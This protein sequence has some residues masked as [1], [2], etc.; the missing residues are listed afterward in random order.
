[1][2]KTLRSLKAEEIG[3]RL[4]LIPDLPTLKTGE[5]YL[6]IPKFS[7]LLAFHGLQYSRS[8][9]YTYQAMPKESLPESFKQVF[10]NQ[11]IPWFI[12][13]TNSKAQSVVPL[14]FLTQEMQKQAVRRG[15]TA[16][17]GVIAPELCTAIDD[18]LADAGRRIHQLLTEG[19]HHHGNHPITS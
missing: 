6:T 19:T 18:I 9:L 2:R 17:H 14:R 15:L 3:R 12:P 10:I 16:R 8:S 11:D 13:S 5:S 7:R 4:K 1:M